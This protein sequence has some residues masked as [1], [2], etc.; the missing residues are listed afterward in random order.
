ML[1][2][3]PAHSRGRLEAVV[4]KAGIKAAEARAGT[5]ADIRA[6]TKG[7]EVAATRA[8]AAMAEEAGVAR[9]TKVRAVKA[10]AAEE[11]KVVVAETK[12]SGEVV[13]FDLPGRTGRAV[14]QITQISMASM[15]LV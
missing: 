2:P 3:T 10:K 8:E 15:L 1:I 9:A 4:D 13:G 11:A 5:R 12:V 14:L 6:A 7:V